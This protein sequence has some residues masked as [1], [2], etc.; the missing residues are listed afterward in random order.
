MCVWCAC[1][2]LCECASPPPPPP[3]PPHQSPTVTRTQ[4]TTQPR[5]CSHLG[6]SSPSSKE[7]KC[8]G[9]RRSA[10]ANA[11]SRGCRSCC[12]C[13]LCVGGGGGWVGG[14]M[15]V[16]S[17]WGWVGMW[18]CVQSRQR[19]PSPF[20]YRTQT[21]RP[22]HNHPPR[23]ISTTRTRMHARTHALTINTPAHVH[24]PPTHLVAGHDGELP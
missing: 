9:E 16:V 21:N 11:H 18:W 15:I 20:P 24:L 13:C 12:C 6:K 3:P 17:C 10:Q 23:L 5:T 4:P 8:K 22:D 14:L 7:R 2:C 1:V 19:I